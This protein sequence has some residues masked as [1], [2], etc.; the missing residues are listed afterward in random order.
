[1]SYGAFVKMESGVE[2]QA[3]QPPQRAGSRALSQW[4]TK[5][6]WNHGDLAKMMGSTV[7]QT[8]YPAVGAARRQANPNGAKRKVRK[9]TS[10]SQ[11]TDPCLCDR[12]EAI[13]R[14]AVRVP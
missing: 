2:D 8:F 6:F 9:Q 1:M 5:G 4:P 7:K 14:A 11:P 13:L 3:H 10:L 12:Q